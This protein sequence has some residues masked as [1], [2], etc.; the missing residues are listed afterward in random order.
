M[1]DKNN[2]TR[3]YTGSYAG[4]VINLVSQSYESNPALT[5][6]MQ[7][8]LQPTADG[9]LEG[10]REIDRPDNCRVIFNLQLTR[11]QG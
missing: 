2:V 10:I 9:R 4:N 1:L 5:T 7:I 6:I 3:V 11:R 8:R